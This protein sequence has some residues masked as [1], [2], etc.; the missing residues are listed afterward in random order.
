M[1]DTYECRS[2]TRRKHT[3]RFDV[4]IHLPN[5]DAYDHINRQGVGDLV[6]A[7]VRY[8]SADDKEDLSLGGPADGEHA[9]EDFEIGKFV[10][11]LDQQ[12]TYDLVEEALGHL[13]EGQIFQL[14]LWE[15]SPAGRDRLLKLLK[16][17]AWKRDL[18]G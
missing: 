3:R 10:P 13:E 9:G 18:V 6:G 4:G 17:D 5:I 1:S 8:L 12:Q 16:E 2:T 7:A 15:L 11:N 14:V